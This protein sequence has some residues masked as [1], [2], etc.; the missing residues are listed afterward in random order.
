MINRGFEILPEVAKEMDMVLGESITTI[1]DEGSKVHS[2]RTEQDNAYV[3]VNLRKAWK[4]NKKLR[5]FSLNYWPP[6]QKSTIQQIYHMDRDK[7]YVPY[8][9]TMD[10][11][12]HFTEPQFCR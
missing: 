5:V 12:R 10:L 4:Q 2:F 7:G 3:V 8:V 1:Y 6:D 11:S 9:S